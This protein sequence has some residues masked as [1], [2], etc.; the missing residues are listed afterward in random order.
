M[1]RYRKPE[2]L[3]YA[4]AL[5]IVGDIYYYGKGVPSNHSEAL[6]WYRRSA[7]LG[8]TEA[9]FKLDQMA[10]HHQGVF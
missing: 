7:D 5:K 9:R 1:E 3:E 8:N 10:S 6:K 2:D 4:N